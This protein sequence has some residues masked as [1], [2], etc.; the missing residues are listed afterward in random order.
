[1]RASEFNRCK[2]VGAVLRGAD[3]GQSSFDGCDF[4]GAD[5][6]GAITEDADSRWNYEF[7]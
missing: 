1:M 6:T 3:L 7:I 2:F 4:T 5:L